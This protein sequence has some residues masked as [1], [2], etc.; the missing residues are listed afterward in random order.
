MSNQPTIRVM[1]VGYRSAESRAFED[2]LQQQGD[3]GIVGTCNELQKISATAWKCLPHVMLMYLRGTQMAVDVVR[4]VLM[5]FPEARV[6]LI[7]PTCSTQQETEIIEGGAW[8][9]L[10]YGELGSHG[11]RAIRTI[12]AGEIWGSRKALSSIVNAKVRIA[13]AQ[14]TQSKAMQTLTGREGEIVKLLQ[15]GS[16]NKEIAAQ[17]EISDKTVK[18]HLHNIFTKLNITGRNKVLTRLFS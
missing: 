14:I 2:F 7:V 1:S 12:R 9:I 10:A 4:N 18:T 11:V 5:E 6:L 16:S 17:L 3:I 8:G 13:T 15:H